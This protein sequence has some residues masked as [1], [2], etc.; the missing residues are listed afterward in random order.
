MVFFDKLGGL[1]HGTSVSEVAGIAYWTVKTA[2]EAAEQVFNKPFVVP[3][4]AATLPSWLRPSLSRRRWS[5]GIRS[6][7]S[8]S[9]AATMMSWGGGKK[10][11]ILRTLNP[12]FS[13]VTPAFVSVLQSVGATGVISGSTQVAVGAIAGWISDI[14]Q[15]K[16]SELEVSK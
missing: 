14:V 7:R 4:L 3:A 16:N 8:G 13:G 6:W 12:Q 1:V 15:K 11:E 9:S 5:P 10:P 2:S